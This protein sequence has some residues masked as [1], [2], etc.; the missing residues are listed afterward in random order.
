MDER[1][2]SYIQKERVAAVDEFI[3][4]LSHY[5]CNVKQYYR[6]PQ[7]NKMVQDI[8]KT[9]FI[10]R[11]LN[12][13]RD[14]PIITGS[15]CIGYDSNGKCCTCKALRGPYCHKHVPKA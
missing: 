8:R 14:E 2:K 7:W 12:L 6:Q 3:N 1:F 11:D 10:E 9:M 15:H 4:E 13:E 5:V